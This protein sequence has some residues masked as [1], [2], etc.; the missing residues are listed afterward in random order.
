[1][2]WQTIAILGGV[3]LVALEATRRAVGYVLGVPT[4]IELASIAP[5]HFLSKPAAAAFN[6][7]KAA[8][9]AAGVTLVVNSSFRD[10]AQQQ[11]LYAKLSAAQKVAQPG[12]SLHQSGRAVDV[13]SGAGKNA[14]FLWLTSNAHLYGFKRTVPSEPWHWEH[15]A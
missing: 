14:A 13:E 9:K 10:M 1:M 2:K 15:T 5:G 4:P 12:W 6:T 3:T 11:A 7:M 8:A